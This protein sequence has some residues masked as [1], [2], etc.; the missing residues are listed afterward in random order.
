M[1]RDHE[2]R[3]RD[4]RTAQRE[5]ER[6]AERSMMRGPGHDDERR[7]TDSG[8]DVLGPE[9]PARPG[10]T[11]T[12]VPSRHRLDPDDP[13]QRAL[14]QRTRDGDERDARKDDPEREIAIEGDQE[15]R[16][17]SRRR[18]RQEDA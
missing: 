8:R 18:A 6:D 11:K 14:R 17:T 5:T 16:L 2:P 3:D 7:Q 4:R 13:V 9:G 15:E 12:G 1:A 10:T